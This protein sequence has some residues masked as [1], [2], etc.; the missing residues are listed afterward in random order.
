[1]T[2]RTSKAPADHHIALWIATAPAVVTSALFAA[3]A[4]APG[5]FGE[6]GRHALLL[7]GAAEGPLLVLDSLL[8][9]VL[10]MTMDTR[11][12]L[13][14]AA[15]LLLPL[16]GGAFGMLFYDPLIGPIL[17][18]AVFSHFV[19]LARPGVDRR[20]R[21]QRGEALGKD[22]QTLVVMAL[23]L[24]AAG[25]ASFVYQALPTGDGLDV[26]PWWQLVGGVGCLYFAGRAASIAH[27]HRRG[28]AV[29]P[30]RL[31]DRR[32][33][34]WMAREEPEPYRSTGDMSRPWRSSRR[35]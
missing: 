33:L 18:W 3:L 17:L 9:G 11:G 5:L 12:R 21:V 10:G 8:V 22:A 19:A 31:L 7:T 16:C 2:A 1:M 35:R 34:R 29:N 26:A 14:V 13:L 32:G 23:F 24:L 15:V 27:V 4:L 20:L 30:K 28:F 6:K 25:A